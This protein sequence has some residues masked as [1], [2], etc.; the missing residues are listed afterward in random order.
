MMVLRAAWPGRRCPNAISTAIDRD[1]L[2]ALPAQLGRLAAG[3]ACPKCCEPMWRTPLGADDYHSGRSTASRTERRGV[4]FFSAWYED[5]SQ[6]GVHSPEICLPGA[7]W[8]IAWLERVDIADGWTANAL[9]HQ[10][11]DH[12]E[13]RN[14]DDGLLLVRTEGPQGR[15]GLRRQI[16]PGRRRRHHRAHGRRAWCA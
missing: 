6:G 11:R 8:E 16:L 13:G 14:P 3:R 7:G 2:R 4:G 5:Q 1:P 9:Q 15:L 12:P 10:P